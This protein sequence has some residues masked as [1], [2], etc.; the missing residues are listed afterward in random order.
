MGP[1]HSRKK[2]TNKFDQIFQA[3][4]PTGCSYRSKCSNRNKQNC[5]QQFFWIKKIT[6]N[7]LHKLYIYIYIEWELTP[8]LNVCRSKSPGA[9]FPV[10]R[11]MIKVMK[12]WWR[13]WPVP[14]AYVW[15]PSCSVASMPSMW[16]HPGMS[17]GETVFW[18]PKFAEQNG[19][20]SKKLVQH[21]WESCIWIVGN[22]V[23]SSKTIVG[24]HVNRSS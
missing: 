8:F 7:Y 6:T 2:P 4:G 17:L 15:A 12:P 22:H 5:L 24:N 23:Q 16:Q 19:G 9:N 14:I 11:I 18:E 1:H 21:V 13:P 10:P 3:C 20:V